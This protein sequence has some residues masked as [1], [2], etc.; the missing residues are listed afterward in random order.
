MNSE[1]I[2]LMVVFPLISAILLKL[3]HGKDR[4]VRVYGT[5]AMVVGIAVP[6]LA[7]YGNHLFG[8][9]PAIDTPAETGIAL[10]RINLAIEYSFGFLQRAL[11]FL[12]AAIATFAVLSHTS[13]EK[14]ASGSIS[15]WSCSASPR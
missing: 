9:H 1:L 2:P 4:A 5:L 11:I 8:A 13:N 7:V 14:R 15:P 12:L 6:L 3:M 10:G